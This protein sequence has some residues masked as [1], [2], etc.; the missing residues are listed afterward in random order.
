MPG[1]TDHAVKA[2]S[3]TLLNGTWHPDA[4]FDDTL[5]GSYVAWFKAIK[6]STTSNGFNNDAE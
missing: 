2:I 3:T 5:Y 1:T 6:I 4:V